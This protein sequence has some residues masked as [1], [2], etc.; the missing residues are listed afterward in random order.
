MIGKFK[1]KDDK[2]AFIRVNTTTAF[3]LPTTFQRT[4][5]IIVITVHNFLN[6]FLLIN[7]T[8]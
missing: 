3:F 5:N 4:L 8:L 1:K 2:G 6:L 7:I